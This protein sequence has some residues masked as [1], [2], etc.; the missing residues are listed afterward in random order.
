MKNNFKVFFLN[1][2]TI[3]N[4]NGIYFDGMEISYGT[5]IKNIIISAYS[6]SNIIDLKE[7]IKAD[8][9]KLEFNGELQANKEALILTQSFKI[10]NM[11]ITSSNNNT[12]NDEEL[13][14]VIRIIIE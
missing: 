4:L 2:N 5:E 6:I 1:N 9:I 12:D 11:I 8:E 14:Y 7:L 13:I 3:I 10:K